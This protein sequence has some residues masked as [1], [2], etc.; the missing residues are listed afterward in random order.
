MVHPPIALAIYRGDMSLRPPTDPD[1]VVS[2]IDYDV[3]DLDQLPRPSSN[4]RPYRG[5]R[6]TRSSSALPDARFL[7]PALVL[8]AALLLIVMALR[9]GGGDETSSAGDASTELSELAQD[10]H[11]A[12][13]RAGFDGLV[14]TEQDGTIIIEG[15]AADP[16]IAASIGAVARSV[17]GTQLVDNRVVVQGGVLDAPVTQTAPNATLTELLSEVGNI[18]FETGSTDITNEG[19]VAVDNAA[20]IL[21]QDPG[22]RI[23]IHGHTDSDGDSERNQVLSQARAEAVLTALVG[24]GI[25]PSRLAAIGFG[26]S[27]PIAPNVTDDGRATN[28]RIE[29]TV[30]R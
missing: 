21:S 1:V 15:Q 4:G 26:E 30:L 3:Y 24:R 20:A 29:F 5:T 28:R 25:D 18:T 13:L 16:T 14:I 7:I 22:A 8:L 6:T 27:Q 9:S 23:E 17:E 10:V 12:E 19:A 2:D 11:N